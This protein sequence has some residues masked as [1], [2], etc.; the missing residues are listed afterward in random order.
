[1]IFFFNKN[2]L[3]KLYW[4]LWKICSRN[5]VSHTCKYTR[6]VRE[7]EWERLVSI[8]PSGISR[9]INESFSEAILSHTI[10]SFY[11]HS[12]CVRNP[13]IGF[14]VFLGIQWFTPFFHWDTFNNRYMIS[15]L[16]R[17][18]EE[19]YENNNLNVIFLSLRHSFDVFF[20]RYGIV[21]A[22][23]FFSLF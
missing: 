20:C 4:H 3:R 1:M 17:Q 6:V 9:T 12:P 7:R 11:V 19:W 21:E 14:D 18:Y 10:N 5:W 13:K 15:I 23:F 22:R 2:E 8:L 16:R